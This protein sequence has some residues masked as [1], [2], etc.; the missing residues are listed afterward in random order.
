MSQSYFYKYQEEVSRVF[1]LQPIIFCVPQGSLLASVLFLL[2][3]N[4]KF[5]SSIY[6]SFILFASD[7]NIFLKH[8]DISELCNTV[9]CEISLVVSWYKGN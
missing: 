7:T 9:N 3:V 4:D 2:Y 8:R 6:L 1:S 5:S